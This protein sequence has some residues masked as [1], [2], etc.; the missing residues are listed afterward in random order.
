MVMKLHEPVIDTDGGPWAK[1][2]QVC[3]VCLVNKAVLDLNAEVFEPCWNCQRKGWKLVKV[4]DRH[5]KPWRDPDETYLTIIVILIC[6]MI[7]AAIFFGR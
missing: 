2:D 5:N 7:G 3:S 4:N 6:I 1:H